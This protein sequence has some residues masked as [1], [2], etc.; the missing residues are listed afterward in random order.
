[1][2]DEILKRLN[3]EFDN[4]LDNYEQERYAGYMKIRYQRQTKRIADLT[5]NGG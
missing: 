2:I 3:K 4:D 5:G 1:M